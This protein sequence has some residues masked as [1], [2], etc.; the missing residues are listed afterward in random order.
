[1]KTTNSLF[2]RS[3]TTAVVLWLLLLSFIPSLLLLAT[4][5]FGHAYGKLISLPLTLHNYTQLLHPIYL[6]ILIQS[7]AL[8][9]ST[10]MICLIL[11]YPAAYI[12]ARWSTRWKTLLLVLLMIP[13][14]TSALIRTYALLAI[15][16]TKGL[17]NTL[18]LSM[19]IIQHPITILYTHTAVLIG[20]VYS[21]LPFMILPLYAHIEKL[22]P[23]LIDAARNL[24]AHRLRLFSSIILPLTFPGIISGV[25]LVF[26]PAMTLFYI[27]TLLGNEKS[28]MLGNLIQSQFLAMQD[29]PGG[30]ATS[31]TLTVLMLLLLL[32]YQ[33]RFKGTVHRGF[34]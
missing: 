22:D 34:L 14:W 28:L 13:F 33:R 30:S 20:N 23:L 21:L 1:M 19:G 26:L 11:G 15:L 5:F 31:V 27:P 9:L 3:A 24:G 29:W 4:S 17:F 8:A 2:Q 7:L 25:L 18:L 12:L 32:Y 6:R 16:K 10:T